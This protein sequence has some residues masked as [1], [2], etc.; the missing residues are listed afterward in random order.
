M[1][2]AKINS[3]VKRAN[4][5]FRQLEKSNMTYSSAYKYMINQLKAGRQYLTTDSKGRIKFRTDVSR[6]KKENVTS[7][8]ALVK[9]VETFLNAN[10]STVKGVKKQYEKAFKSFKKSHNLNQDYTYEEF[11]ELFQSSAIQQAMNIYGSDVVIDIYEKNIYNLSLNEIERILTANNGKPISN[12][13]DNLLNYIEFK[14]EADSTNNFDDWFTN[15]D[16][17]DI[18][19]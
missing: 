8:N 6:L 9:N 2:L 11:S 7:F 4:Q 16:S 12:I 10:T 13:E 18:S 19:F 14:N 1:T 3:M 15:S 5:R 17:E